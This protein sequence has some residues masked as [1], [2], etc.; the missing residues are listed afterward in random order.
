LLHSARTDDR[1]SDD[2]VLQHPGQRHV[3]R[4]LTEFAT[5]IL[6]R[7]QLSPVLFDIFC[8]KQCGVNLKVKNNKV[9]DFEPREDFPFSAPAGIL[10]R[11]FLAI[12]P[13]SAFSAPFGSAC[14]SPSYQMWIC[15]AASSPSFSVG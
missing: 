14:V 1:R 5:E 12:S 8:G 2:R 9:I 15:R 10:A 4:F 3:G 11:R 7:F 6:P 13:E